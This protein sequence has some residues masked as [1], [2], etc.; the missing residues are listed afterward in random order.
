MEAGDALDEA[1]VPDE[2]AVSASAR[3]SALAQS[4]GAPSATMRGGVHECAIV[5]SQRPSPPP[6]EPAPA[7]R[8]CGP[9]RGSPCRAPRRSARNSAAT[10]RER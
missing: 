3:D 9:R 8:P 6:A 1:Q 10:R 5:S 2:P 4:T 7:S